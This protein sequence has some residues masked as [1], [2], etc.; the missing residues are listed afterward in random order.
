MV[1]YYKKMTDVKKKILDAQKKINTLKFDAHWYRRV[2]HTF[3]ATLL[4]YYTLPDIQWVN[5]L[6]III[7]V[8]II[9]ILSILEF[10]RIRGRIGAHHFFGLRMYE[11]NRVGSYLF[12][13]IGVLILLLFFPQQ[14]AIPCILCA[15]I[16]DP[17]LGEV[18][19]KF[20]EKKVYLIGL[21]LCM[22]LFA[23]TWYKANIVFMIL[24][25]LI[26]ALGAVVGETKKF[27]W[28]DDDFMIQILPAI[29]IGIT[30]LILQY[31][32]NINVMPEQILYPAEA[33]SWMR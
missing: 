8:L 15:C 20:G 29:L 2:F 11:K 17:I 21:P 30:I 23:V 27:F 25:S 3:G 22:L 19:N 4:W 9:A 18:R 7:P 10:L 12:F 33:P 5:L 14:I 6:K 26:G 13:G 1:Q 16:A 31:M 24:I 28:L 32:F